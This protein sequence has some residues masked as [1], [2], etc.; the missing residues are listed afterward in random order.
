M[1]QSIH[2]SDSYLKTRSKMVYDRRHGIKKLEPLAPGYKSRDSQV[3]QVIL[4]SSEAATLRR[5]RRQVVKV[6]EEESRK[7]V[8]VK[9]TSIQGAAD[10]VRP[11]ASVEARSMMAQRFD[12]DTLPRDT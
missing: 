12:R 3:S 11:L 1:L 4:L 7:M 8:P 10:T 6:P 2:E 9:A 5:N